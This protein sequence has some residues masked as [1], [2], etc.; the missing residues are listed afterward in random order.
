MKTLELKAEKRQILGRKVKGLRKQGKIPAHVFGKGLKT[1]HVS[2]E[3][4]NFT[5]VYD[6]VGE[7]G[8]VNLKVD[9]E[10]RPVLI[11]SIQNHP[12]TDLP[13]HIDFYQVNLKEKVKVNVPLEFVGESLVVEKKEGLLLTPL[14]EVEVEALPTDLPEAIKVD[15]AK[16]EH[17]DD[18]IHVKDLKVDRAKVEILTDPEEVVAN[19]G[20]LVTK[21]MEEVEA[22]IEA[23]KAEAVEEVIVEEK[24]EK[25]EEAAK[26]KPEAEKAEATPTEE[27]SK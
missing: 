1:V 17:L 6:Q 8:L 13:L 19:I 2:V 10:I 20:E 3:G 16:L 25:V 23:E 26:E 22:E 12:V 18:T 7:T 14:S 4:A 9:S 11:R 24:E 15:I 21:K 27:A 5:K